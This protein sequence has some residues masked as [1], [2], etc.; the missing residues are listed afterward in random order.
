M[1]VFLGAESGIDAP[2]EAS[3]RAANSKSG[4]GG[5]DGSAV[6]IVY[7]DRDAYKESVY[8]ATK[9]RFDNVSKP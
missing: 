4:V 3:G 1:N 7:G 5:S 9:A 2:I 6:A 8:K